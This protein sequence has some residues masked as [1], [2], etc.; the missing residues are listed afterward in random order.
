M[1]APPDARRRSPGIWELALPTITGNVVFA[2]AAMI[3]TRFVGALGPQAVAAVG[4]SHRVLMMMQSLFLAISIGLSA[5]IARAWGAED[6][7]EVAH[8]LTAGIVV[9][10]VVSIVF[11][12]V[13][14]LLGG[15]I[16]GI[17]GLDP[18]TTAEAAANVRW[19]GAFVFG[20]ALNVMV[21]A[22]L[23]AASDVMRPLV[24]VFVTN[25]ATTVLLYPLV[26]GQWGLPR[27]HSAGAP[28]SMGITAMVSA[29]VLLLLWH[30]DR[31]PIEFDVSQWRERDR[32]R[33][34]ID[35]GY[36]AGLEQFCMQ[37]GNLLFL[38]L[39]GHYY[40]KEAFAAYAIGMNMLNLAIVVGFG[41]SVAGSTLVGQHLGAGSFQA[42]RRAGWRAALFAVSSMSAIALVTILFAEE[43]ARF[44]IGDEELTVRYTVQFTYIMGATLPLLG[45]DFAIGGSLRGAGDTRFPLI[46]TFASMFVARLG[47]AVL[48]IHLALP[49]I[50]IYS[51]MIVEWILRAVLLVMRFRSGKWQHAIAGRLGA[52]EQPGQT[53]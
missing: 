15:A 39:I 44:F 34:L 4:V 8:V 41:F 48:V 30:R 31:L 29:V 50:W 52:G 32:Y 40:G 3:Q 36:P 12:L 46:V 6:R 18:P 23:R 24:V 28:V 17:F 5:L 45:T 21:L 22:A 38:A 7:R 49:V 1:S 2:F 27:L 42:A 16:A 9:T 11:T 14:L 33:R 20:F 35:I 13:C 51:V 47:L 19:L 37:G 53:Y 25:V 10:G 43:L 26:F